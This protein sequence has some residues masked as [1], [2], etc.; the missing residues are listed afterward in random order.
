MRYLILAMT[1]LFTAG[2]ALAQSTAPADPASKSVIKQTA[3]LSGAAAAKSVGT[4]DKTAATDEYMKAQEKK[5]SA[6]AKKYG[7]SYPRRTTAADTGE[8]PGSMMTEEERVAHRN[9]LHSFKTFDECDAYEKQ[10]QAEMEA[11]AKAQHKTLRA[12]AGSACNRYKL[13]AAKSPAQAGAAATK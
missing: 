10:H 2:F 12:S 3:P 7:T 4:K 5:R 1:A 8:R 13:A 9:K 11:R 6:M